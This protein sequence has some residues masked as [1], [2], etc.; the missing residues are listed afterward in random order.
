MVTGEPHTPSIDATL[1]LVG[2]EEVL[3]RMDEELAAYPR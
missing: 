1:E 3:K 2:R